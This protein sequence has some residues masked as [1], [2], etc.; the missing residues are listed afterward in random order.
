MAEER[1]IS[2]EEFIKKYGKTYITEADSYDIQAF[3]RSF[4][5]ASKDS[6]IYYV[7]T[8]WTKQSPEIVKQYIEHYTHPGDI[9]LDAFCGSGITGVASQLAKCHA[10]LTDISPAC[11]HISKNYNHLI[12]PYDLDQF[13]KDLMQKVKTEIEPLY[14]T[15]CP[16]CKNKNATIE[17]TVFSDVFRCPRCGNEILYTSNG[18]WEQMKQGKTINRISC[19]YCLKEFSKRSAKFIKIEPI[20]IRVDCNR[21]NAKGIDKNKKL[22]TADL[23]LLED[24]ECSEPKY[25]YPKHVKFFGKEPKRNLRRNI[26][27]PYQM[28]SRRNLHALSILWHHIHR[29]KD[30]NKIKYGEFLFT[31]I[32]YNV[33]LMYT[34]R[35]QKQKGKILEGVSGRGGY[36]RGTLYIP[37]I[38][39][40]IN[41]YY[42]VKR[43]SSKIVQ[44]IS[45]I[46]YKR[47]KNEYQVII[48]KRSA[49]RLTEVLDQSIDYLYYDP[50]YGSNIN[51]SELNIMWEA[52]LGEV[53]DIK[54]EVIENPAQSKSREEYGKMMQKCFKEAFRI[55][56]PGRWLSLVYSHSDPAV[57]SLIQQGAQKAGFVSEE[58]VLHIGSISKTPVQRQSDK[59]Q[60]RFLVLNFKK[61][62]SGA[63]KIIVKSKDI[64]LD[65]IRV[66]QD[67][68]TKNPGKTRDYIYDQVI[69]RL[70]PSIKIQKFNLDEILK[71]FFRKVGDEWYALGTLV[72]RKKE[73]E[74]FQGD[75]FP[76]PPLLEHP[77]KEVILQLQEFLKKYGKAPYSEVREFYLRKINIPI[78]R[79]FDELVKE[80]FIVE[81][82]KIRLPNFEEQ[83][84]MQ[85]VTVRYKKAQIR[86]F[87]E[88]SL[89]SIPSQTEICE[90]INF[91]YLN[92]FFKEGWLLFNSVNE[93]KVTPES[94]KNTKKIAEICKIKSE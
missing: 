1:G 60:Q 46:W 64:E 45:D 24:L 78:E 23:R 50:P 94:Y 12:N 36:R 34:W 79:D 9:V 8:Y 90:W 61:P 68:L 42:A 13:Y 53:T 58:R 18:R 41:V 74:E 62:K 80:N 4:D 65:V 44:G 21:C 82:G 56:K 31:S 27:C 91:C 37:S 72:T 93:N 92:S 43:A 33:S 63:R 55:L 32:I 73:K 35:V 69:K 40:D 26:T 59:T 51:Y 77:E 83:Q 85:D 5:D 75:L 54:E 17:Y 66:V 48:K 57:Y 47:G 29:E 81:E 52:W 11:I 88:G 28:F 38:I 14:R 19:D 15:A 76:G 30:T 22:D 49:L 10:I 87:L 86:W 3:N 67:F 25:W 20:E 89:K 39:Q 71:N 70:F 2:I 6:K 16:R 84:R 7:H